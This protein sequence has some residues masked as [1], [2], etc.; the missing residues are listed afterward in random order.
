MHIW[1]LITGVFIGGIGTLVFMS[2]MKSGSD[3]D[4]KWLGAKQY[5]EN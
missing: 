3:Y 4:D 2:L 1:S 5:E